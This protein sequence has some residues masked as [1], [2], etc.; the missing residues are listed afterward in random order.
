MI[1]P[2]VLYAAA[3]LCLVPPLA[4]QQVSMRLGGLA[5]HYA[6]SIDAQAGSLG[7]RLS[8]DSRT[9]SGTVDATWAKFDGAGSAGQAW[10]RGLLFAASGRRAALG[11]RGDGVANLIENGP[12]SAEGTLELVGLVLA[13]PL[14]FSLGAAAGGVH[15]LANTGTPQ[16]GASLRAWTASRTVTMVAS[17]SG[18]V[19]GDIRFADYMLTLD[20]RRGRFRAG[21]L[22]ATRS[23]D[24]STGPWA[25]VFGSVAITPCIAL[26]TSAGG[27]PKDLTGFDQ[28]KYANLGLRVILGGAPAALERWTPI[29]VAALSAPASRADPGVEVVSVD[30]STVRVL[31]TLPPTVS[32]AITGDWN[33][34]TPAPLLSLGEN[35]W[36]TLLA[37]RP[38]SHRFAVIVD[39][40]H[41]VVPAGVTKLPD[42]FGGEV[43]LLIVR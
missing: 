10:A 37:A 22:A 27:Y 34:W 33:D 3:G 13:G 1:R 7:F 29:D 38:G 40:G 26:E 19:A 31:L 41:M 12:W 14:T 32:A 16:A 20:W 8:G 15:T 23:G 18:V 17:V 25:Q 24:L 39:G 21:A 43:G 6:D 9:A 2:V 35:R 36:T 30:D 11:L 4:A 5:T 42:D 28:G